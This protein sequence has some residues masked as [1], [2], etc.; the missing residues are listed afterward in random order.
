MNIALNAV[1]EQKFVEAMR[2]YDTIGGLLESD[3]DP[4]Y[5]VELLKNRGLL[6]LKTGE[7]DHARD[8]F[9]AFLTA[10]K[11]LEDPVL[12]MTAMVNIGYLYLELGAFERGL[13]FAD[14][15]LAKAEQ[16]EAA[17]MLNEAHSLA[18]QLEEARGNYPEALGH[19]EAALEINRE[20]GAELWML[21]DEVGI[22]TVTALDGET[23]KARALFAGLL[24]R[25]RKAGLAGYESNV[26]MGIAHTFEESDPGQREVL[27]RAGPVADRRDG[28]GNRKRRARRGSSRRVEQVLLRGGREVFR[29]DGREDRG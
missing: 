2:E 13:V 27:L 26:W 7:L 16:L 20:A 8:D 6:Y 24:P 19:W 21:H 29:G 14:S 23:G 10:A 12:E 17:S 5:S 9:L 4:V 22:A 1:S 18:A 11:A 3:P 25:I 15:A 28:S